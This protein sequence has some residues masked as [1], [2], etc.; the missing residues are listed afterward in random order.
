MPIT[1]TNVSSPNAGVVEFSLGPY[2]ARFITITG[3]S[4]YLTAG[5]P[6]TAKSLGW[7]T[8]IG[9]IPMNGGGGLANTAGTLSVGIIA[10]PNAAQTEIKLLAQSTAATVNTPHKELTSAFDLSAYSGTFL[11]IGQ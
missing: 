2:K 6:L 10:R 7:S 11:I 1:Y 5:E 4:S 3:D 9:L 8:I